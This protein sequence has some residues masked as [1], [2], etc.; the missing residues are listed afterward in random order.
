MQGSRWRVLEL[1]G[2]VQVGGRGGWEGAVKCHK[3]QRKPKHQNLDPSVEI[4]LLSLTSKHSLF[5]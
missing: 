5:F 1:V 4:V 2:A 3:G